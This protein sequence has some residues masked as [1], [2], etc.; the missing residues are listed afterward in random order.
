MNGFT[1][2]WPLWG[3]CLRDRPA[4]LD[5]GIRVADALLYQPTWA[6]WA[7]MES[8]AV[9]DEYAAQHV[10]SERFGQ[11]TPARPPVCLLRLSPAGPDG[12]PDPSFAD[13]KDAAR[14]QVD[15]FRLFA[16]GTFVDPSHTGTYYSYP[17]GMTAREVEPFRS[18]FY[19]EPFADDPY[20]VD[21]GDAEE[22]GRL[23]VLVHE[24]H[25]DPRQVNASMAIENFRLSFGEALSPA[26]R[27]LHLFIALESLLGPMSGTKAGVSF[28]VRAVSALPGVRLGSAEELRDKIAHD[29]H[30]TVPSEDDLATLERLARAVLRSYVDHTEGD[31]S[32]DPVGGFNKALAG[33]LV[34][35]TKS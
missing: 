25:R 19:L 2:E 35:D 33:G 20:T 31:D 27:T 5:A 9:I 3:L 4:G 1:I 30:N 18:G 24:I 22:L 7:G 12:E 14:G 10:Y 8:T 13:Q 11:D 16:S 6:D 26:E 29:L 32:A 28:A 15:A 23:G 17:D 34:G 21:E